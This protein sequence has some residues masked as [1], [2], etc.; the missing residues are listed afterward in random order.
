VGAATLAGAGR[1]VEHTAGAI[2]RTG[3]MFAS[4]LE[5]FCRTH[6]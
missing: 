1:V 5:P 6:F 3:A 2:G 4:D